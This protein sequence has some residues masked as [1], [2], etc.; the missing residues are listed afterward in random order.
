MESKVKSSE[1]ENST[2]LVVKV[3]ILLL[4]AFQLLNKHWK[5]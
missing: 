2:K 3:L 1:M 4:N 5:S